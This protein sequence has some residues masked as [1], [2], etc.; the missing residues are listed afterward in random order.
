MKVKFK[1][2]LTLGKVTANSVAELRKI[3]F[4][5]STSVRVVVAVNVLGFTKKFLNCVALGI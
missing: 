1:P 3:V 4:P 5:E 2:D